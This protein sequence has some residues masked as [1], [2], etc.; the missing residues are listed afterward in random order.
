V[1]HSVASSSTAHDSGIVSKENED[2]NT[3]VKL[4]QK[5]DVCNEDNNIKYRLRPRIVKYKDQK[6]EKN[7]TPSRSK[8]TVP[9]M[10]FTN[11]KYKKAEGNGKRAIVKRPRRIS[12]TS[13]NNEGLIVKRKGKLRRMTGK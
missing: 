13:R 8:V 7:N 10:I 1:L 12:E 4:P 9:D 11:T 2:N 3:G 6:F 5:V